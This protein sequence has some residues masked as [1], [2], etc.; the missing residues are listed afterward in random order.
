MTITPRQRQTL[1]RL[2]A[3]GVVLVLSTLGFIL[4][5]QLQKFR[6][7]GYLGAFLIALISNATILLPMPGIWAVFA[8]GSIFHPLGVAL[9]AGTGGALGELSGYL[10][11]FSGQALIERVDIFER[12]K[13]FVQKYGAIGIAILSAIPNPFFDL[14]GVAAGMLKIPMWKFLLAAWVGQCIKMLSFAYAGSFSLNWL[15]GLGI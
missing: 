12:I 2:A 11:G 10:A 15:F 3:L 1:L 5:D 9:A 6:S 8:M 13:P 7:L 14:A 4:Q